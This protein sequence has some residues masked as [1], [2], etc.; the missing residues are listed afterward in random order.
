[1]HGGNAMLCSCRAGQRGRYQ[2]EEQPQ[3]SVAKVSTPI[4][5]WL[6]IKTQFNDAMKK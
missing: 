5:S 3:N 2:I 4:I 6:E 1:M